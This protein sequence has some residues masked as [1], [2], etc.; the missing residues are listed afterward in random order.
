[1]RASQVVE[2][3]N[4]VLRVGPPQGEGPHPVLFMLHGWKGDE[5]VMWI[6]ADRAPEHFLLVAPR[7]PVTAP[8]RGYSWVDRRP[9]SFSNLDEF[10]EAVRLLLALQFSLPDS[11]EADWDAIH[12]MGFSQGAAL[13]YARALARPEDIRSVAGLAGFVPE[14]IELDPVAKPLAG[15]PI[16][17]AHGSQDTTVPVETMRTGISQLEAAGAEVSYCQDSS[18]HKLSTNCLR[19]LQSFYKGLVSA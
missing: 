6:F 12:L 19:A 5:D 4:W 17:V 13:C 2:I 8:D 14:G 11:Y 7:A 15:K 10:S 9:Q 3:G 18:G 16:F 1:M